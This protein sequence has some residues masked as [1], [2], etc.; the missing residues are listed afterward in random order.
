MG[1]GNTIGAFC[2]I[3]GN[4]EIRGKKQDEFRGHVVIGDN[5]VISEF[6]SIQ[7]PFKEGE[8]TEIGSRNIIMSHSHCGHSVFVGDDCEICT[9]VILG[10][11]CRV[12]DGVRIKLN[13]TIRNRIEI[14]VGAT[15]GMGS[16][17]TKNIPPNET[18]FGNPAK[19]SEK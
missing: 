19:R 16:A 7:R 10:G 11:H 12:L 1:K 4:G 8:V 18:W 13:V 14:G 5:N 6:V 9:G 2:V 15:I 3:G 17:V